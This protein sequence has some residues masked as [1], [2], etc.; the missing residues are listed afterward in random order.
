MYG[1][2]L[3]RICNLSAAF[4]YVWHPFLTIHNIV[5]PPIDSPSLRVA[6][7]VATP[8]SPPEELLYALKHAVY[9]TSASSKT[10]NFAF[11]VALPPGRYVHELSIL[12][13]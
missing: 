11:K 4:C 8:F 6:E 9:A 3:H 12:S 1:Y 7:S 10:V 13:P 2:V 5:H